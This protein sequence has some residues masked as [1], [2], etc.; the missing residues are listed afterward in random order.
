MKGQ[1]RCLHRD[2]ARLSRELAGTLPDCE[3]RH[4]LFDMATRYD[5]I[6]DISERQQSELPTNPA[7]P[8]L[9]NA[10]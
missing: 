10:D 3:S 4:H 1:R 7:I 8:E 6:A 9:A 2:H 5:A